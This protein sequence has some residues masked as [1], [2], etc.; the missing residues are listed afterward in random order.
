MTK[1]FIGFSKRD[2]ED[3]VG[4]S[5]SKLDPDFGTQQGSLTSND[6]AIIAIV[7]A[8]ADTIISKLGLTRKPKGG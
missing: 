6:P 3:G 2:D 1:F 8:A 5:F 4:V 7:E